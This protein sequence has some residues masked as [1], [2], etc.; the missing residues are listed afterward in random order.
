MKLPSEMGGGGNK[1]EFNYHKTLHQL[2][3]VRR[4]TDN[5]KYERLGKIN[6][7][8]YIV[9]SDK[10]DSLSA[11]KIAY[12]FG[13]SD[14]VSFDLDLAKRGYEVFMYD[15]TIKKLPQ[16][17]EHFHWQKLGLA[18][19]P[20]PSL[21]LDALTN[22]IRTNDHENISGMFLKM[23]IEGYE[24]EVFNSLPMDI[25]EKFD[26]IVLEIHDL[27][28]YDESIEKHLSALS[29]IAQ[30]HQAVHVHANNFGCVNY[31]GNLVTPSFLEVTYALKNKYNFSDDKIENI[32]LSLD[33]PNSTGRED[34]ELGE[35]NV[36]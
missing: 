21:K 10:A 18:A 36:N 28:D 13:I 2:L 17:N 24:W 30:T 29:K 12:S 9:V 16:Y 27:L 8:G 35:W 11:S 14:D 22:M 3:H 33:R 15:H 26:Q 7:G 1:Y 32:R 25:L 19:S 23:D 31:C 5:F 6:D 34:L 4:I 20:D